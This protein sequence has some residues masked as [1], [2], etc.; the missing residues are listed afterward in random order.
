MGE[1][2]QVADV[3]LCAELVLQLPLTDAAG[4]L[5]KVSRWPDGTVGFPLVAAVATRMRAADALVAQQ[6]F[7][8][9]VDEL[10]QDPRYPII[11]R[12]RL[13]VFWRSLSFRPD[14]QRLLG[15]ITARLWVAPEQPDDVTEGAAVWLLAQ[16]A[17]HEQQ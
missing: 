14:L 13:K 11:S 1:P 9:M 3:T 6:V 5:R 16:H 12:Q 17:E 4:E 15:R 2:L 10:L 7:S 8:A